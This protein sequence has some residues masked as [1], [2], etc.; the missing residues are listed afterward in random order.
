MLRI[1]YVAVLAFCFAPLGVCAP[2][3]N[4][5]DDFYSAIRVNDLARVESLLQNAGGV[6]TADDR[7]ITPLMYAA[8]AGST[9]MMQLLIDKGADVNAKNAFGSTALIWSAAD[10]RKVRILVAHGAD[11]NTASRSGRTALHVAA[12]SDPSA[13]TVRLLISKGA[14]IKTV[15]NSKQTALFAAASGNDTETIRLLIDAGLDVN[16]ADAVGQTPLMNAASNQNLA[17]VKMLLAQG[18]N[19]N[20]VSQPP[21]GRAKNGI[22]A[23]GSFT[24]LVLACA[25]APVDGRVVQTLLDAGGN[26]DAKDGRGMTPLML[27]VATDHQDPDA[28][29]ALLAHHADTSIRSLDGETALDWASKFGPTPA[30]EALKRAGAPA[31]EPHPIQVPAAAPVA[32]KTAAQRGLALMETTSASFFVKGGCVSCHSTNIT[33]FAATAARAVGL[34]V[35]EKSAL[36]RQKAVR[37]FFA[38]SGPAM[39]ERRDGGGAPDL[40][41]YS[42]AAL[43]ETGYPPD[44]MTDAIAANLSTQQLTGGRWHKVNDG[45]ARPPLEDGD[46]FRT[47]LAIRALRVYG[48]PGRGP[49]MEERI[50]RAKA[51]LL[52]AEPVTSE[53]RNMRLLGLHWAGTDQDV[54]RRL[55]GGIIAS[56]RQD[57]GWAQRS[58]P[59]S[60]AYATGQT[61]YV[62][63]ETGAVSRNDPAW[64]KGVEYLRSTQRADGSWYVRSRAPK[65]QPYFEIGFPY[66]QDQ[67]ISSMA[68]G[69]ATTAL[70]LAVGNEPVTTAGLH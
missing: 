17:A 36:D 56:Q 13:P 61:L 14:N 39:L 51:W 55:A 32:L 46:I 53:D 47:T 63:H 20:A 1:K 16:A 42:L 54:L 65:F 19:V 64:S 28:I 12:L 26:P 57:G 15:D 43:A 34:T 8:A 6:N 41:L 70:A 24:P 21:H 11:V 7:G 35:D 48:P 38:S 29:R 50:Q 66:G 59:E 27:A 5:S 25:F 30:F 49:E 3:E 33:D 52:A 67:W 10:I 18:A 69:W 62:L 44:R 9:E 68:T 2:P 37:A 45:V 58:E 4:M 60:D 22:L 23:L 40:P 31:G